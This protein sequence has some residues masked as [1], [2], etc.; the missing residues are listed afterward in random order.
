MPI[1]RRPRRVLAWALVAI[2]GSVIA[3][4]LLRSTPAMAAGECLAP[5]NPV[6]AEN[7][8]PGTPSSQWDVT[9]AGSSSIQGFATDISYDVG[10]TARFKIDTGATAY[11]LDIYR[12]GYYGGD[13]ARL[14]A[15]VDPSASLPQTQ[16]NCTTQSTTG[17]IDCGNWAESASWPIPANAVS[18]LYFAKLT[19]T[20]GAT[21]SSHIYFVVRNDAS[22]SDIHYQTSDTTWQAYNNYGGNSLYQ[23]GPGTNPSR[24]YKV[25]YNRPFVTRRDAPE[26]SPFNAEYPMIRW[27]ERNGYDVSYSTGV[28]TDRRGSLILNHRI[29]MSSGH[30]EYWS[31]AQRSNVEAARDAGVNLAFFSGNE[32]F[33]KTR[34]ESSIAGPSTTYRTLVSYKE[35][36]AGS[37]IDPTS[38]WTGTWRDPR[39]FNPEGANPENALTGTIFTVNDGSTTEIKVPAEQGKLRLWRNT[40]VANLLAGQTATLGTSTL[41]YEWDSDL[42]NG[43]RPAGLVDMSSTTVDAAS[44]LQDYGSTYAPGTRTHN[45]T[46]YRDTNGAGPDALVFGAGTVQ[47]AWG[48]DSEHDRGSA[49]PDV[50]MQQATTNLLADM[51]AQPATLQS[52]LVA[53]TAS[54]DVT[55]PTATFTDPLSGAT[56]PAGTPMTITGTANDGETGGAVGGVEVSTDGQT[57]HPAIGTT[58]W[59]YSWTPSGSG[60]VTLR[61]RAVDDSG[62]LQSPVSSI[63]VTVGGGTGGTCPCSLFNPATQSPSVATA[64]NDGQPLELGV[65][66]TADV[67]GFVSAVRFYKASNNTGSH[68]G[69]LWTSGGTLLAT[70]TFTSESASG[71]QQATFSSPI[72]VTA[73]TTY[74][75]SYWSGNGYYSSDTSYFTN[76][77]DNPPLHAPAGSNGV[78]RYGASGFP[79]STWS[80][81]NYWVDVAFQRTAGGNDTTPPTVT[82]T[83][84]DNGAQAVDANSGVTATF[85]EAMAAATVNTANF[86]LRGPGGTLVQANV[87]YDAITRIALLTPQSRLAYSTTYTA[88]VKGG[89]GGFTDTSG[90]ALAQDKVWSFTTAGPPPPPPSEGPGGPI[91]ILR[92][93]GDPWTTYYT[94]IMRAEGLNAFTAA[95]ISTLTASMLDSYDVV[96]LAQTGLSDAQVATLT[97]WVQG[98]GNLIAMRPD[99]KLAGLLGLVDAAATRPDAYLKVDTTTPAGAGVTGETVQYHGVAD[100]YMLATT[101]P[102]ANSIATLYSN[103]TTATSNPAVTM[104]DIGTAGGQAA[105]FTYDLARSVA[106]TRQG[107]PAWAGDERD[108]FSPIR[109]DD[110]FYGAQSGDVQPDWVNLNKISVPQADE[111]QRLL[112]NLITRMTLDRKPLPRF[113][114]L[115][116]GEKAAVVMTGDDHG[117]NGTTGRF[118][119]FEAAS[120]SGC[121][122]ADWECV[123]GTS[124][125]YPSTPITDSQVA[126]WQS[127]GFEIGLHVNT[128]CSDYTPQSLEDDVASQLAELTQ[129][130]PSVNAPKTNRTHCIVWSDWSGAPTVERAHGI[131]LDTNYYFW[132]PG[133]VQD[134]PGNFTGSGFPMRFAAS[135]GS[136]IDVYQAPTQITDESGQNVPNTIKALIDGALGANGYY[137]VF[138]ANMH[139]DSS[140]HPGADA[141]VA[142]ATSRSVPVVSARQMLDWLDGRNASSFGSMAYANRQLTFTVNQGSGA[143][144]LQGMVPTTSP[145]GPLQ[146]VTRNGSVIPTTTR[147]VKG[148]EYAF[149]SATGGS[150]VASYA[151]DTSPPVISNVSA[152]AQLDGTATITWQTDEPSTSR[153]RFGT[154]P[155][156]LTGDVQDATLTTNH[157]VKFTGLASNT[158]FHYRVTSTDTAGNAATSPATENPPATFQTPAPD[159]TPPAIS[160]VAATPATGGGSAIVTWQTDEA[161]TTRVV[162]GTNPNSLTGDVQN[163]SLVTSHSSTLTGLASATTYYYRVISVDAAGNSATSPA[164]ANPPA[165]FLTP[166]T[167]VTHSTV[168]DFSGGSGGSVFVGGTGAGI[169][170]EVVLRPTV[171]EEFAGSTL[172]SGWTSTAWSTGGTT[173]F[174]GG[175]AVPDGARLGTSS[176]YSAVLRSVEFVATFGSVANRNVGLGVAFSSAPWAM[177]STGGGTLPVG[178]YA[179]SAITST[180][181]STPISGVDPSTPHRYRI[182]RN[183]TNVQYYIDGT[184]VATHNIA[185]TNST[186]PLASDTDVGAGG[187]VL[188]WLRLSPVQTSGTYTSRVIDAGAATTWRTLTSTSKV[189]SGT[190]VGTFQTR[191]STNGS[192]N[193]ST[194]TSLGTGGSIASPARRYLQYRATLTTNSTALSPALESVTVSWGN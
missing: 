156:S 25:S 172:P 30:D 113:W 138:T 55:P 155:G 122:V 163:P 90:N 164:T 139:T 126:A 64:Y 81:S 128:G 61:A 175:D 78:Y 167:S 13:G 75:A 18:G 145:D 88:T 181:A 154:D 117:N 166:T 65:K 66:F 20:A 178:L 141:I 160:S 8:L 17:L 80:S 71:W 101:A 34:W 12:M 28:D 3:V 37:K 116:G 96:V 49:A 22:R 131:R 5:A 100:R 134:R 176:T 51:G 93:S 119:D 102:V 165:S 130:Y 52:G 6:V 41:G 169:D 187:V 95:D 121:S 136:L 4:G 27:L 74:V 39:S 50:P 23:G 140:D 19:A 85:S 151:P 86:E 112:A 68:V 98:G 186:R 192:T 48:L 115:P 180:S 103:A 123:R 67:D 1:G 137:G 184:L 193:W 127:A 53:A 94:E 56:V 10:T 16:P 188:S 107:N 72:P 36:H 76:P 89:T 92:D 43:S 143:R 182:V 150:Y 32:I 2:V 108:G 174:S 148:T 152:T 125:V 110:L 77:L 157:S 82:S 57:W 97:T 179:R 106:W 46:L 79:S 38:V 45:L 58:S 15:T 149:L 132:P 183:N 24:A 42:D 129:A 44:V 159:T 171:A 194:W 142:E 173:T 109:S 185:I 60:Q 177:F 7:C 146:Q 73:G 158:T 105:A 190:S 21:G 118:A 31:G 168:A 104:R 59:R 144:N 133:W 40:S 91:L 191:T 111:Q 35:T 147:T 70:A 26:D 62:N 83:A 54:S 14:I 162:Y 161:S 84:P 9:G 124:Y 153:V 170:G 69:H 114:Y 29:F 33:W 120:P 135:N 87:S 189:P 99:K 63:T 47:W 11:R